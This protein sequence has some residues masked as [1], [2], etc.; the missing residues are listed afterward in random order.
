MDEKL[1]WLHNMEAND[2]P[3]LWWMPVS[4]VF[5][6]S[7]L[8]EKYPSGDPNSMLLRQSA[9]LEEIYNLPYPFS[10]C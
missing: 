8:W 7:K 1:T 4:T 10:R 2:L 5:F 3:S 9:T 6:L